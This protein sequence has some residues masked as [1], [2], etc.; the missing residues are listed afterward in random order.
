MVLSMKLP[1][2]FSL[3][4]P[5]FLSVIVLSTHL[6]LCYMVKKLPG[7]IQQAEQP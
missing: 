1:T 2:E 5:P 7:K 3:F 6:C 4:V